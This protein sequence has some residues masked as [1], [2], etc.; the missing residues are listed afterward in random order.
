MSDLI[1]DQIEVMCQT[2][3]AHQL[4]NLT[5]HFFDSS[6]HGGSLNF[7]TKSKIS[8]GNN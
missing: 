5:L 1:D 3:K 6:M 2:V 8:F 7:L 4:K